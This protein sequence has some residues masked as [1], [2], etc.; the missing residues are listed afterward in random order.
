MIR[1]NLLGKKKKSAN[2]FGLNDRLEKLGITSS[3]L[4]E[5]RPSL[6][7]LAM[8]IVGLYIANFVP[9]YLHDEKLAALTAELNK[10]TT[11]SAELSKELT[12]KKDIRKQMEQL[13]KEEG[14]LTRQLNAVAALQQERNLSFN[15]LN[16]V[17]VQL[18]KI[19][20]VWID[21]IQLDKRTILLHGRS[22][23]YFAINDFVKT[24]TESTKYYEV[25]VKNIKAEL[26]GRY[27]K[28]I[29]GV[30]EAVQKE[31]TF[32]LEFKIKEEE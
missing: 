7:R 32:E 29:P 22:W 4:Q 20:K 16:D 13:T 15:T 31:K 14:E 10:L 19:G 25:S 24:I 5:M 21:D 30:P 11:K 17:M 27:A 1:I 2:P 9:G 28:L 18:G 3:D 12:T 26:S 23:E 8:L 6:V